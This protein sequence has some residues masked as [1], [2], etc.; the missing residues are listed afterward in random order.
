MGDLWAEMQEEEG[1]TR[2]KFDTHDIVPGPGAYSIHSGI[3]AGPVLPTARHGGGFSFGRRCALEPWSSGKVGPGKY[4][5][6]KAP[7]SRRQPSWSFDRS[8]RSVVPEM[9]PCNEQRPSQSMGRSSVSFDGG[10]RM[11]FS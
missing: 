7:P 5:T 4:D 8:P 6:R 9:E 10:C 1:D 11:S 2:L 3:G